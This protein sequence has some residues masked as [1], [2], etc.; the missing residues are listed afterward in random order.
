MM[1][2]S[3]ISVEIKYQMTA[4]F[5]HISRLHILF[6]SDFLLLFL[7]N[8]VLYLLF[9]HKITNIM[10]NY[11]GPTF[12]LFF[13]PKKVVQLNTE[14]FKNI[15]HLLWFYH[16]SSYY[17][18]EIGFSISGSDKTSQLCC[19]MQFLVTWVR[20]VWYVDSANL[21]RHTEKDT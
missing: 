3:R 17:Y 18:F 13:L 21:M 11:R 7:K 16:L 1:N 4:E 19:H 15:V 2:S 14:I 5:Q 10:L 9:W 12:Q 20:L 8:S 6:W